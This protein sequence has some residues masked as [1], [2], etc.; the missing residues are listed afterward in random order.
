M[1]STTNHYTLVLS[2]T[3]TA[4]RGQPGFSKAVTGLQAV[5]GINDNWWAAQF[6]HSL[7]RGPRGI[8]ALANVAGTQEE[9]L[10]T[11]ENIRQASDNQ[12]IVNLR[13]MPR[14]TVCGL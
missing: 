12:L 3:D 2:I 7:E 11:A 5:I 8:L 9:M 6:I 4:G 10:R 13:H 1:E 14:V